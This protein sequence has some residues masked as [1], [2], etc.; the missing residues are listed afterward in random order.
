M[1]VVAQNKSKETNSSTFR[2]I[3]PRTGSSRKSGTGRTVD[4]DCEWIGCGECRSRDPA[5]FYVKLA[6]QY[7]RRN[8]HILSLTHKGSTLE[9]IIVLWTFFRDYR[10]TTAHT[11]QRN[12]IELSLL[13][14]TSC[15]KNDVTRD[16]NNSH[17]IS[18]DVSA[19]LATALFCGE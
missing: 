16:G 10:K 9:L 12:V 14:T 13:L 5:R 4:C 17:I 7:K 8:C 3:L 19:R 11:V 2:N 6:F 15:H 1:K 18:I